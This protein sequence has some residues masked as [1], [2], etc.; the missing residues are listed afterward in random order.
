MTADES[1]Y[2]VAS[3]VGWTLR[4]DPEESSAYLTVD[5]PLGPVV[6]AVAPEQS[7]LL[8]AAEHPYWQAR[9]VEAGE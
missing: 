8:M 5:G 9:A 6:V 3:G 4:N 1:P 2:V 7:D